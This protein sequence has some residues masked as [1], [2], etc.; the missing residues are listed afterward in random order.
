V[1]N[2]ADEFLVIPLSVTGSERE[3]ISKHRTVG[4]FRWIEESLRPI[5]G[6]RPSATKLIE[7]LARHRGA[8]TDDECS[9]GGTTS[10]GCRCTRYPRVSLPPAFEQAPSF[11]SLMFTW[12]SEIAFLSSPFCRCDGGVGVESSLHNVKSRNKC[13]SATTR[14]PCQTYAISDHLYRDVN[15]APVRTDSNTSAR[16]TPVLGKEVSGRERTELQLRVWVYEPKSFRPAS[17]ATRSPHGSAVFPLQFHRLDMDWE[18]RHPEVLGEFRG[19]SGVVTW[20]SDSSPPWSWVL[21]VRA[22][23]RVFGWTS[24]QDGDVSAVLEGRGDRPRRDQAADRGSSLF[25]IDLL[26]FVTCDA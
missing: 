9:R 22:G 24:S 6:S 21:F 7:A 26:L 18:F 19:V 13:Q 8:A 5:S 17:N 1:R 2:T 10:H 3:Q 20:K 15:P 25:G 14:W 16:Q 12:P 23:C 11:F 4:S